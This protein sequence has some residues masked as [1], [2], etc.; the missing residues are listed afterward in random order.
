VIREAVELTRGRWKDEAQVRGVTYA[1]TTEFADVPPVA[2]EPA[3]LRE[4]FT[5]LLLNAVDAMPEGG[6]IHF[7]VQLEGGVVVAT[8]RDSGPGMPPEVRER[9]FEPFFTTK[10]PRSTGLGLSVAYGIIKRHAGRIEV[11][12]QPGRGAAFTVMLPVPAQ[13]EAGRREAARPV[14]ATAAVPT[15]VLVIDDERPVRELIADILRTA[16]HVPLTAEDGPTGLALVE[17]DGPPDVALIDLGL[18]GM[19][20]WE[21]AARLRASRPHLPLVLI[22][23]WG[24]RLDPAE[25]DRSGVSEVIAKPFQAEQILRVVAQ[26]AGPRVPNATPS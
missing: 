20:G 5:N 2:G 19:S 22:T 12:S 4:V 6:T 10:G 21:V 25:I 13:A 15:R 1:V 23:G 17:R 3:E 7:G 11:D 9:V 26:Q 18:P 24:D 14:T 16:G 8:V